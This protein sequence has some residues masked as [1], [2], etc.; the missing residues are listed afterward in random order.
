VTQTHP[1]ATLCPLG[2]AGYRAAMEEAAGLAQGAHVRALTRAGHAEEILHHLVQRL[3]DRGAFAEATQTRAAQ[4]DMRDD[5]AYRAW[6]AVVGPQDGRLACLV[7]APPATAESAPGWRV[8]EGFAEAW[9]PDRD[10]TLLEWETKASDWF[11]LLDILNAMPGPRVYLSWLAPRL[12]QLRAQRQEAAEDTAL[13][14]ALQAEE[15]AHAEAAQDGLAD[16]VAEAAAPP[17]PSR[18]PHPNQVRPVVKWTPERLALAREKAGKV[19]G[20]ELLA[21]LNA[22]PGPPIA[23]TGAMRVKLREMGLEVTPGLP[24]LPPGTTPRNWNEEA[25]AAARERARV[26]AVMAGGGDWTEARLAM[27]RAEFATAE[28]THGLLERINALP[29]SPIASVESMRHKASSLG[30]SRPRHGADPA[31]MARMN[32]ARSEAAARLREQK[33][34]AEAAPEAEALPA[35]EPI[36]AP[37]PEPDAAPPQPTRSEQRVTTPWIKRAMEGK[38]AVSPVAATLDAWASPGKLTDEAEAEALDMLAQGQGA[39]AMH[40]EFGGR[41]EWW[42][43]WTARHRQAGRAA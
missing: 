7:P 27:L 23:S 36:E 5:Q 3:L 28:T 42:Q 29:G 19:L 4:E 10:A 32:A 14:D 39:K 1:L 30:L 25:R 11:L 12:D 43:A 2:L 18:P 26:T 16:A 24:P 38:L 6:S 13:D 9:T 8:P 34:Q 21:M 40:E 22:L 41:L 31:H 17:R 35:P 33:A 20:R 37:A 15:A